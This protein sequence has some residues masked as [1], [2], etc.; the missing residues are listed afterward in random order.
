MINDDSFSISENLT[1]MNYE[2][3][4]FIQKLKDE[5]KIP[6]DSICDFTTC[7]YNK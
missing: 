2:D 6:Y 4:D 3:E 5:L 7:D 1:L